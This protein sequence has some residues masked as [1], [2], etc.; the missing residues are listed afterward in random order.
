MLRRQHQPTTQ[1]NDMQTLADLFA[2][3][4]APAELAER[5]RA[6]L[7]RQL[8]RELADARFAHDQFPT[9]G[10]ER[11]VARLERKLAEVSK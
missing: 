8:N 6:K 11:T 3:P 10:T 7:R 5:D 9:K 1:E 4:P 2:V